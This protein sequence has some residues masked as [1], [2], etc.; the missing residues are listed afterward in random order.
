[1]NDESDL[2]ITE[3][4]SLPGFSSF[5][6][7]LKLI[8]AILLFLTAFFTTMYFW[9]TNLNEAPSDFPVNEPI[10]ITP[11]SGVKSITELLAQ[12]NI[13]Q[14]GT[15][16]YYVLVG[17]YDPTQIKAS[18]YVFNEPLSTIQIAERLTQGDFDTDLI[19]FTHYE[20]ERA[21]QI[22]EHASK[23]LP[24]FNTEEFITKAES[25]EGKL[26]PDT[27]FIPQ[28][29]DDADL[30]NLLQ[31][32]FTDKTKPLQEQISNSSLAEEEIIILASIIERE[33][34]SIESKKMVSGILQN[35]MD[36]D[37]PLQADASI[38][39][40]LDKPLAELKPSDLEIDTPYNTYLYK[41]LPPTPIGNP[42]L[43]AIAAVLE[44]TESEYL[45]YI[46]GYDGE[47]YYAKT[48]E[49]HLA[50]IDR[51]LRQ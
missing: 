9:L 46:T 39:Y 48:Y 3:Q 42:G 24:N 11:G 15:L 49:Q 16:L 36:I 34:N 4:K 51:Y 7:L 12:K 13:V 5:Q 2:V 6:L 21:T 43:D 45:F 25:L 40:I 35:R 44:P 33:A 22:A 23:M 50:N 32:T 14:S 47:F 38:E 30:I 10:A 17:F 19:R 37:M 18:T 41:G 1:M 29:F 27:Y 26:F 31:N 8:V 28:T 20:G